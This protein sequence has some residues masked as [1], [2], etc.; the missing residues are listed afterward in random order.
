MRDILPFIQNRGVQRIDGKEP[1]SGEVVDG[2]GA[3]GGLCAYVDGLGM[4]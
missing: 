1:I 4:A 2:G 3:P